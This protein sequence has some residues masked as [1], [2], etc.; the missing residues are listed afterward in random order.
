MASLTAA[1]S[2]GRRRLASTRS[3]MWGARPTSAANGRGLLAKLAVLS[4]LV[5]PTHGAGVAQYHAPG[6]ASAAA[7]DGGDWGFF[8][9][10]GWIVALVAVAWCANLVMKNVVPKRLR[11]VG[12]QTITTFKRQF[13]T[14]RMMD[15]KDGEHGTWID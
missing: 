10:L 13:A 4:A 14:P 2:T 12:V 6:A 1:R 11:T 15:L 9:L 7:D 8:A 5:V 3:E